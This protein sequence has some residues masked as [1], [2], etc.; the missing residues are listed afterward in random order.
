MQ[1]WSCI[2]SFNP[3]NMEIIYQ[4]GAKSSIIWQYVLTV[5]LP[6]SCVYLCVHG[7]V[8]PIPGSDRYRADG[9]WVWQKCIFLSKAGWKGC[10]ASLLSSL[11]TAFSKPVIGISSYVDPVLPVTCSFVQLASVKQ[12]L[13]PN[14]NVEGEERRKRTKGGEHADAWSWRLTQSYNSKKSGFHVL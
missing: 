1:I 14:H 13:H 7:C 6:P 2:Q 9:K 12:Q 11:F 3:L 5:S 10:R 8:S 4:E